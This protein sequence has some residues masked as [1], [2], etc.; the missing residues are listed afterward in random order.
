[1]DEEIT[2]GALDFMDKNANAGKPFCCGVAFPTL[3]DDRSRITCP[4]P[5]ASR[6]RMAP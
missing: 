5:H 1:V 6:T 4:L 3:F 2:K